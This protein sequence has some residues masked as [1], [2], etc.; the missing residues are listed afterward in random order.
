MTFRLTRSW[1]HGNGQ[2]GAVLQ[3]DLLSDVVRD[4]G[5]RACREIAERMITRDPDIT[6]LLDRMEKAGLV[7]RSR[8][9]KDRRVI[10]VRITR[11]GRGLLRRLDHPVKEL[12]EKQVSRLAGQKLGSLIEIL[13]SLREG[14]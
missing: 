1:P 11:R 6:R 14:R 10:T 3:A 13:E 2:L 7:A 9:Q 12:H 4:T 8:E 5:K